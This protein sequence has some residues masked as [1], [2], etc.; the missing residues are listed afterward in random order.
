MGLM[1]RLRE[2]RDAGA[3]GWIA[4]RIENC[5]DGYDEIYLQP[6]RSRS[7]VALLRRDVT[8]E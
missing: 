3:D 6:G 8:G 4:K 1:T 7:L 5:F 2:R